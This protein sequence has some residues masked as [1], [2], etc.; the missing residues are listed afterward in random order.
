M[1]LLGILIAA[2]TALCGAAQAQVVASVGGTV[3]V[4]IS[5]NFKTPVTQTGKVFCKATTFLVPNSAQAATPGSL[6]LGALAAAFGAETAI[7][8]ANIA[9][10]GIT[11][12]NKD[13]SCTVTLPYRW[14]NVDPTTTSMAVFYMVNG[15]NMNSFDPVCM[16]NN[17]PNILSCF[18]PGTYPAKKQALTGVYPIPPAATTWA[19]TAPNNKL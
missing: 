1:K 14:T 11:N 4:T 7:T 16:G 10:G 5:G 8:E 2:S 18:V 12:G 9:N 13:W 3:N 6:S 15:T 19:V 17:P